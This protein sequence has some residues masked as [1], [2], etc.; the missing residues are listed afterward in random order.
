MALIAKN[1]GGSDFELTP[2]GNH[3]AVCYQVIDLG[4]QHGEYM[5]APTSSHKVRIAWELSNELMSD[6]RPF[7]IGSIFTLSLS[8][9]SNLRPLLESWRG[10]PFTE[11][12]LEGFDLKNVLGA[13]CMVNV[14]HKPNQAGQMRARVSS[15]SALPKGM[16]KPAISNPP[17]FYSIDD[18]KDGVIY[19]KLDEWLQKMI[20]RQ[21]PQ[22]VASAHDE[23]N[24]PPADDFLNDPIPF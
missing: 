6:G 22:N 7:S 21:A 10:R 2:A 12:E 13:A 16:Q 5:G 3:I 4:I 18:D 14:I 17:L 8:E 23:R 19:A 1:S 11:Q 24:P 15:V 9:K 20:N